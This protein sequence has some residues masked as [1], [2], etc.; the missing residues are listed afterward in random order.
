MFLLFPIASATHYYGYGDSNMRATKCEVLNP[1]PILMQKKYNINANSS[2]NYDGGGKTTR[3]GLEKYSE[4][5]NNWAWTIFEAFGENDVITNVS[6]E[7]CAFNKIEMY[8][9]SIQNN[10]E[11]KYWCCIWTLYNFS[12]AETQKDYIEKTIEIFLDN[13]V[14]FIP[15]YDAI[16]T[17]PLNGKVDEP[18]EYFY[19]DKAHYN[20][21]AVEKLAD[22]CWRF[23]SGDIY[24]IKDTDNEIIIDCNY[25]IPII[26]DLN[27]Y[28][29]PNTFSI[30]DDQML[31][32]KVNYF[33]T[34]NI[35][36]NP[37]VYFFAEEGKTYVID[38]N[39]LYFY[40]LQ[41]SMIFVVLG[42]LFLI[43]LLLDRK[44][45]KE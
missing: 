29:L 24:S 39:S 1:F 43:N 28:N 2:H 27:D 8:N 41:V 7:E 18:D 19:C 23:I 45:G 17:V 20:Y 11:H 14:P 35:K 21:L 6:I 10:S 42:I 37:C 13:G 36:G 26:L 3:W 5:I 22:F 25:T 32:K 33:R 40:I 9:R 15:L 31:F 16:D 4:H 34:T 38:K 12:D 44:V 30:K